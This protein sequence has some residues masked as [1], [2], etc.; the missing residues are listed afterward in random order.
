MAKLECLR[1]GNSKKYAYSSKGSDSPDGLKYMVY[2][3]VA[4]L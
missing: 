2:D 3:G 1:A 4:S